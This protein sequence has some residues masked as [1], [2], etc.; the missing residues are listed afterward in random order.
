MTV[1]SWDPQ[2]A[3]TKLT[4]EMLSRLLLAAANLAAPDFGLDP[5]AVREL[6]P[7]VRHA[8]GAKAGIDWSAAAQPLSDDEIT[9]LVR[10]FTLAERL[11][12]WEAG[13]CSPVIPLAAVLKRR[14]SY[15]PDLTA[16]IKA[17]SDNRFLPY[18]NLLDR[19]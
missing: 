1:E 13:D 2:A 8:R 10:L 18:G 5:P 17:N 4:P 12:G 19:L 7:I 3:G 15:P 9:A 16:W 6:A 14:G 11:P